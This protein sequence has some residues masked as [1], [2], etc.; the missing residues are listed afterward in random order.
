[1][2]DSDDQAGEVV[3]EQLRQLVWAVPISRDHLLKVVEAMPAF[4][5]ERAEKTAERLTALCA[6][7][8]S[9]LASLPDDVPLPPTI[10]EDLAGLRFSIEGALR[11]LDLLLADLRCMLVEPDD[12]E[13]YR[14]L[15]N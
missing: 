8:Q 6:R 12:P 3:V 10:T 2:N 15:C 14:K 5:R 11:D 9:L 13:A 1:M 4:V 7:L